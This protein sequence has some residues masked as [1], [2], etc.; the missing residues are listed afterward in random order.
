[1]CRRSWLCRR[2][3][4]GRLAV[5]PRDG[6]DVPPRSPIDG[7]GWQQQ[8]DQRWNNLELLGTQ[9]TMIIARLS[10][11]RQLS[12]RL[13]PPLHLN[14]RSYRLLNAGKTFWYFPV[15]SRSRK[16][17]MCQWWLTE[18][19]FQMSDSTWYYYRYHG[20]DFLQPIDCIATINQTKNSQ[21]KYTPKHKN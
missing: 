15:I 21:E 19:L 20:D 7:T 1:V 10:Y 3:E 11:R 5:M 18:V 4:P 12:D 9:V 14:T 13:R 2:A 16:L 17:G 8:P 6:R